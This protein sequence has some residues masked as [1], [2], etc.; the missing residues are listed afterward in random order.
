M[1]A[2][3]DVTVRRGTTYKIGFSPSGLDVEDIDNITCVLKE[4][5]NGSNM[6]P[7]EYPATLTK[8]ATAIPA[9]TAE[10]TGGDAIPAQY[11]FEMT[12]AET[13]AIALGDYT[14][15]PVITAS[16]GAVHKPLYLKVQFAE[17]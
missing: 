9:Q 3:L 7:I 13:L 5:I 10:E 16:D 14:L 17:G 11:V 4:A 12:P 1:S 2:I 6:R 8:V 15:M